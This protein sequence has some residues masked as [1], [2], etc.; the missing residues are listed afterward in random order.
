MIG[1]LAIEIIF[2]TK[3]YTYIKGFTKAELYNF[4]FLRSSCVR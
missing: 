1:E 2:L 3:V 4:Q